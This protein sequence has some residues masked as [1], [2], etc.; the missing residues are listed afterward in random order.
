MGIKQD[1]Q[2][3][4]V[5]L[6]LEQADYI[7][8]EEAALSLVVST[9]TIYRLVKE[10]NTQFPSGEIILSE[11][12]RG[13]RLHYENYLLWSS[14]GNVQEKMTVEERRVSLLRELL[15]RSPSPY[16][17]IDILE[18][19]FISES[20]LT[21]DEVWLGK[22][23]ASYGLQLQKKH[24]SL[25]ILGAERDVRRALSDFYQSSDQ[26]DLDVLIKEAK[27]DF[28]PNDIAF[29]KGQ[30]QLI[31]QH[32]QS[33][34]PYP[35][36]INIFLHLYIF[37]QRARQFHHYAVDIDDQLMNKQVEHYLVAEE[38]VENI[39]KYLGVR[40]PE[41]E[42]FYLYQYL[43]AS[44]VTATNQH[45]QSFSELVTRISND[46]IELMSFKLQKKLVSQDLFLDLANHIQPM[47]KR[48]KQAI[49][50]RNGLL[51]QIKTTYPG[52]FELVRECSEVVS[53]A[54]DLPTISEDEN[55]F[56]TLYFAKV[57]EN[58][59]QPVRV[60]IVCTTG[61]GISELL[62]AKISNKFSQIEIVKVL[63]S[64]DINQEELLEKG[65]QLLISTIPIAE[66]QTIPVLLVSG[67]FHRD[68][69]TRLE[70]LLKE[71]NS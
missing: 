10:I 26:M 68:D 7:S 22:E 13:Y 67:M 44:R 18:V 46:Y 17:I 56:I 15:L 64:K 50:I 49:V 32:Y 35:Y 62:K 31:E 28:H 70:N 71:L 69:Q 16:S 20:S 38:I 6:L 29:L 9:K 63:A 11:K 1:R 5:R 2:T 42:I 21:T 3:Q 34:L 58:N 14:I 48:L 40:V 19:Y 37:I 52:L 33:Q 30:I 41:V 54:Y 39:S 45:L 66:C 12:G 55:G 4:L 36:N 51:S 23:L 47:L 65:V 59:Q 43:A 24:R 25:A 60:V 61:I 57:L 27:L 53:Q 8:S